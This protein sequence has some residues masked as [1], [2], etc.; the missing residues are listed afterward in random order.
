M[1]RLF[2]L[3]AAILLAALA[4]GVAIPSL[5]SAQA[6]QPDELPLPSEPLTEEEALAKDARWYVTNMVS[7]W[8]RR[9]AG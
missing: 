5:S 4:V 3:A 1:K 8:R 6:E 2:V 9:S 7:R